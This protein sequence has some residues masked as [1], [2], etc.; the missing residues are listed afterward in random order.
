MSRAQRAR[1]RAGQRKRI[2]AVKL[3]DHIDKLRRVRLAAGRRGLDEHV[4]LVCFIIRA[5]AMSDR[6]RGPL[7]LAPRRRNLPT[8]VRTAIRLL[9]SL[10]RASHSR[11]L[12]AVPCESF[13][14]MT[15]GGDGDNASASL[16][17]HA[18]AH[19]M[20]DGRCWEMSCCRV[21]ARRQPAPVVSALYA[22]R[23]RDVTLLATSPIA[24]CE[25]EHHKAKSVRRKTAGVAQFMSPRSPREDIA[26]TIVEM[27]MPAPM[28]CV[29]RP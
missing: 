16:S 25:E 27:P 13:S 21:S 5:L 1:E 10:L 2:L 12:R 29:A 28:H 26:S 6:A 15:A 9:R 23:S 8:H 7:R 17:A 22:R 11:G 14:F 20:P 4:Q 24:K 18:R 19:A 3:R